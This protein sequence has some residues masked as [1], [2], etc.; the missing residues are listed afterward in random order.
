M[1]EEKIVALKLEQGNFFL[2]DGSGPHGN[3]EWL[4]FRNEGL[5]SKMEA[6]QLEKGTVSAGGGKWLS[7]R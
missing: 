5:C 7:W 4:T 1:S 2:D 3:W 6:T